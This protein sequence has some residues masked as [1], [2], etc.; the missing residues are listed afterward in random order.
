MPREDEVMGYLAALDTYGKTPPADWPIMDRDPF[1]AAALR[2]RQ[3]VRP[4]GG[5]TEA[6]GQILGPV[7][8]ALGEPIRKGQGLLQ[9]MRDYSAN[10]FPATMGSIAQTTDYDP[11]REAAGYA[12]GT[13]LNLIGTPG[14]TGGLGAGVRLPQRVERMSDLAA[15]SGASA[16]KNAPIDFSTVTAGAELTKKQ[17]KGMRDQLGIDDAQ[18]VFA[19]GVYKRPDV[20]AREAAAQVAPEHPA[21]K[22]LFGVTRDDLYEIGQRGTRQGNVEPSY[23]MP[24]K[25]SGSYVSD[26]LMTPKNAQRQIDALTEA[27]K[28]PELIKGMDSWYV[29]DPAFQRMVQLVGKEQAI[30]DYKQFN[31]V[32]PMFSPA[33]PVTTELNRGTAANMMI[34]R[35]QW[36]VFE[37]YAGIAVDDRGRNFPAALRDVTPHPYHSTAQSGPVGRFLESGK[38]E[39][40]QPKVPLYMQASGVPETGFQTRLPV[41]DAHWGRSVGVAD[42]RTTAKPG[43]SLK[44]PE[45][46]QLGP[47]Y[48]ENV[49]KPLG[50]EAVPAQ[51]RQWGTYAPQTGVDTPIGA[52]KLELLAQMIWERAAKLG[53]DPKK[54]RDDVL[55]G[56]EHALWILGVPTAG[57]AAAKMSDVARQDQYQ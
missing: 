31:T 44:G 25:I 17:I 43:V 14:G 12:A 3:S 2:T 32:V 48:R 20:I 30:K 1:E 35:G 24:G 23:K 16:I 18:R 51:G 42:V 39:M 6:P 5:R 34:N 27:Q 28:Y 36:P 49:A 11:R 8:H 55:Q 53:I 56:K 26:A 21:M 52:P 7:V 29:M 4:E 38:I 37:R 10:E 41:P 45:Y 22:Q 40:S 46:H 47:W 9:T 50:I 54:L 13:A 57:A 19:P 15:G 33:S